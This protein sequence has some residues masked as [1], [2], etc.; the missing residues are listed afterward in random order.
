MQHNNTFKEL[1]SLFLKTNVLCRRFKRC[2]T[3]V[4]VQLFRYFLC[5]FL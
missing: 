3:Q 5:L 4:K 2:S 1:K